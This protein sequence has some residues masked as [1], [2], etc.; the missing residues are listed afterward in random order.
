[1]RRVRLDDWNLMP[2]P[3]HEPPRSSVELYESEEYPPRLVAEAILAFPGMRL[4]RPA[5]PTWYEW[6]AAWRDGDDQF[7][8][9]MSLYDVD[10]PLW[11]G[12]GVVGYC[13]VE[14]FVR[15][16]RHVRERLPGVWLHNSACEVHS[17]ESFAAQVVSADDCG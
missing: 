7:E 9:D 14:A 16:C 4:V 8:I 13:S 3:I 5:E 12:T 10:P 17:P 2:G 1:M 6:R 15:F 11:G